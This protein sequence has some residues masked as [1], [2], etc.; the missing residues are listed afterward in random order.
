MRNS[1]TNTLVILFL[2]TSLGVISPGKAL[3]EDTVKDPAANMSAFTYQSLWDFLMTPFSAFDTATGMS[4]IMR[5]NVVPSRGRILFCSNRQGYPAVYML[6]NGV[7]QEMCKNGKD[8]RWYSDGSRFICLPTGDDVKWDMAIVDS[9]GKLIRIIKPYE[10]GTIYEASFCPKN[11]GLIYFR[12]R[13]NQFS[14]E[15]LY[16]MRLE[17][18]KITQISDLVISSFA[19]SPD[20]TE[21]VFAALKN[22]KDATDQECLWLMKADG[23]NARKLTDSEG[24]LAPAWSPI[25]GKIAFSSL[26]KE[27]KHRQIFIMDADGGNSRQLTTSEFHKNNP[28]WSPD[29]KQICYEAYTHDSAF[30]ASELFVINSNSTD[31]ARFMSP[32]KTILDTWPT[33]S[34]PHWV[35][36]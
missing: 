7:A 12:G 28:C 20:G 14:R 5:Y 16:S 31:E 25:G 17:D 15:A 11:T 21:I 19:V 35:K 6:H 33:E 9:Q 2:A 18:N 29:G 27:R 4:T 10:S 3:A 13:K 34:K 22:E 24:D 23:S 8:G 32:M 26:G 1:F 36:D 30:D